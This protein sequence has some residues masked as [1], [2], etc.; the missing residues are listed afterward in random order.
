MKYLPR[1]FLNLEKRP[2]QVCITDNKIIYFS[3]FLLVITLN[4]S[5][6]SLRDNLSKMFKKP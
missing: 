3:L 4:E 1:Q 5:L 2:F 6:T